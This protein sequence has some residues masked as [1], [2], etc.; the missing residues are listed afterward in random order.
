MERRGREK[1]TKT[2]H[3]EHAQILSIFPG[4]I[5]LSFSLPPRGYIWPGQADRDCDVA[6]KSGCSLPGKISNTTRVVAS[7]WVYLVLVAATIH[8][9]NQP[10]KQAVHH[11]L[12]PYSREA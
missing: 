8:P 10:I 5:F 4:C 1:G 6:A 3:I 2:R 11:K 9:A 12:V 7:V